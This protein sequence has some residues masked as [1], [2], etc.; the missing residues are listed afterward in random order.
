MIDRAHDLPITK[1]AA[2]L[3]ISRGERLLPAPAGVDSRP[4]V[5]A[6]D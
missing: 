2:A 1:Q 5:H 4:R 6:A 3:T